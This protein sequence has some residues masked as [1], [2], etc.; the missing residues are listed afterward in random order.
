MSL[1]YQKVEK[2]LHYKKEKPVV[3]QIV[4][5]T[6]P[7]VDFKQLTEEVATSCGVNA[8]MTKAVIEALINR[9]NHFMELGHAVKLGEL[10]TF[11]PVFNSKT[12]LAVDELSTND[13]K[14]VKI[15]FYP[16]GRFKNMLSK[17]G[18]RELNALENV[19]TT[20]TSVSDGV[21][22]SGSTD[23]GNEEE[24]NPFG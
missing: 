3:Y 10:G 16:G 12:Q 18:I 17:L 22:D 9:M 13:V 11:K 23:S 24:E 19:V 6:L 4:Q 20:S 7:A 8:P 21:T 2:V 15:R 5:Q 14:R 1:I